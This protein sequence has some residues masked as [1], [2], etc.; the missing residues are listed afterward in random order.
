[1]K[2]IRWG[3]LGCAGIARKAMFSGIM[4]ASNARLYAISSRTPDKLAETARQFPCEKQYLGYEAVLRD[5]DVDA[6]YIPLPNTLHCE[7]TIRALEAG[8]PVLCEKPLAMNAAEVRRIME[9][10]A[11]TGVPVMEAFAYLHDPMM[12]RI[13]E[14]VRSGALGRLRYIE[15]NFSYLLKDTS[16]VRLI[17]P[18]GGGAT[19]DLGCYPVSFIREIAGEEPAEIHTAGRLGAQTGVDEDV[20]VQMA[21]ASGLH[22]T[23]YCSF[24]AHWSTYNLVLGEY[25]SIEFPTIFDRG[26]VKR[27]VVSTAGGGKHE[28][29]FETGSRYSLQVEQMGRVIAEGE[30]PAISLEFSLGN[31]VV[32]DEI[33]RACGY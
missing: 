16:N 6:V 17:R 28:E 19:Y 7:W 1:M 30:R 25:G 24:Q 15:A 23:S 10:S 33:L 11:R 2:E 31:A 12:A 26:D 13:R 27:I 9:A 20:L 18:L 21:F 4:N 5:P 14:L 32:M 8:K 29:V 3:V 22:A